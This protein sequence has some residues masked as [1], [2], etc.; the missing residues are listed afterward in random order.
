M[1]SYGAGNKH[2]GTFLVSFTPTMLARMLKNSQVPYHHLI[3][4]HQNFPGYVEIAEI[5]A[6]NSSS[7]Q[8]ERHV[9]TKE[10]MENIIYS[11]LVKGSRWKL[12]DVPDQK[13]INGHLVK[14]WRQL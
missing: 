9:L 13:L 2:E 3:L 6:E 8:L 12:I 7:G 14:I 1:V 4:L 11:T 10:Q 5:D